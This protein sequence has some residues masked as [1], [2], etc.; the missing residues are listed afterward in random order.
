MAG[1]TAEF[2]NISKDELAAISRQR[3]S[4]SVAVLFVRFGSGL[5]LGLVM[6]PVLEIVQ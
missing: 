2:C 1:G 5:L 6:V 4:V 3:L